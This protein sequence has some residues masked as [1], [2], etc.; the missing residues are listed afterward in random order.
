[1]L[2]NIVDITMKLKKTKKKLNIK[3][4][5]RMCRRL[6]KNVIMEINLMS[7]L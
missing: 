3:L 1:M 4:Y 5:E 7:Y 6:N 2:L